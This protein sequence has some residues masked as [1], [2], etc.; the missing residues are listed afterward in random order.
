[1]VGIICGT[2]SFVPGQVWDNRKLSQMVDTS[3][4][5][6]RERTGVTRRHIAQKEES[7]A[8][9]ASRAAEAAL[10]DAGM[11]A[12]EVELLIVATISPNRMMPCAACEVQRAV[13]AEHAV[14]F[15]LNAACTGFLFALNTAQAYISQGLYRNAVVIGAETLSNLTNWEDRSTC[16]LFGDGAGAVVLKASEK[17]IYEQAAHSVGSRGEVLTCG[18]RNQILY[19]DEPKAAE[20]YIQM[21]GREVFQFA[22]SKVPEVIREVLEKARK[23]KEEVDFYLLHQANERIVRAVA[24]RL[25]EAPGKFPVNIGEYGNTSSASIPIL[26]DELH[27]SGKLR[28]GDRLILSGFGGGLSYGA[29]LMQWQHV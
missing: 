14:C 17:G 27:K 4:E 15:D 16:I 7:T 23:K 20:T 12:G 8:Y 11:E 22:V 24:K 19:E 28:Q 2:G 29:S 25:G 9:M 6:I 5:W 26:L 13:G 3:D 21:D 1:M 18:S 10:A